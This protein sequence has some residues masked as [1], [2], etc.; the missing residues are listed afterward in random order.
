METRMCKGLLKA[1][2]F[3]LFGWGIVASTLVLADTLLPGYMLCGGAALIGISELC[4]KG[5][6]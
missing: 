6:E 5:D 4:V 3:V 2:G 1:V